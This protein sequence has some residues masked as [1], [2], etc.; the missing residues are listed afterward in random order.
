MNFINKT[1]SFFSTKKTHSNKHGTIVFHGVKSNIKEIAN[2]DNAIKCIENNKNN[3]YK[4]LKE[5]GKNQREI[6]S[7]KDKN[8]RVHLDMRFNNSD[9][10]ICGALLCND[11]HN[12]HECNKLC[13][14]Y[15]DYLEEK[16]TTKKLTK[17]SK[18]N[19]TSP[20]KKKIKTPKKKKKAT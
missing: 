14:K 12:T 6:F 4:C 5:F 19:K 16:P 2:V 13:K 18:K 7:Y 17:S 11:N 15:T 20:S 9:K 1:I 8:G 3:K 10:N